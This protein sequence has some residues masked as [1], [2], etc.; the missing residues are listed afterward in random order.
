MSERHT[1][2]DPNYAAARRALL[3]AL[4]AL[5][6]HASAV[7]VAGAQAIYLRTGQGELA[8]APYTTDGDLAIDPTLLDDAPELEVAMRGA[9]FELLLVDGHVEPGIWVTTAA[10]DGHDVTIPV[11]LIVPDAAAPPGGRRGAR[12]GVHGRR[13]ARRISGLE[14]ALVDHSPMDV[15]ALDPGDARVARAEVAGEAALLVAKAHKIHDRYER[16][17]AARIDD[18]DA[19]DVVRLMQTTNP[20]AVGTTLN[21]LSGH[22]IAGAASSDALA[23][24]DALFGRV[25]RPGVVMAVRALRLAM[26]EA[27]IETLCVAYTREL[28]AVFGSSR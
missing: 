24:L 4:V 25:G 12:L 2:I 6:P 5:E 15:P 11:D 7:I 20:A 23:F 13:A 17:R 22:P 21:E 8:V 28:L 9:G 27:T 3:D 19:A 10:V 1:S 26:P 16:G 18:K 14:A